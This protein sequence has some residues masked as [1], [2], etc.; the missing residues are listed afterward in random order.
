MGP[1]CA[2]PAKTNAERIPMR[3]VM[4]AK[5]PL[6]P[7]PVIDNLLPRR[8]HRLSQTTFQSPLMIW[9]LALWPV[10]VVAVDIEDP[11][12]IH[13]HYF[14]AAKISRV[15]CWRAR[16]LGETSQS[17]LP[18]REPVHPGY[19]HHPCRQK[20]LLRTGYSRIF[21]RLLFSFD[22]EP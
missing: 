20:L 19:R 16:F 13:P 21:G 1:G 2:R 14:H 5:R 11:F 22:A 17:I 7:L 12:V 15:L 6:L 8:T 18:I 9:P 3:M 10:S 4:V